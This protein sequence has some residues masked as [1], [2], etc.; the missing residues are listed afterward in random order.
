[1]KVNFSAQ[2]QNINPQF[3]INPKENELYRAF[4]PAS[5]T[6][7][8]PDVYLRN[9]DILNISLNKLAS[10]KFNKE[11]IAK[12]QRYGVKQIF[13]D[14]QE[15]LSFAKNNDIKIVFGKVD[16]QDVH[17]QWLQ[18]ENKI[19]IND[20]YKD[21][22]SMAEV[23]A[24]S[25]A[26]FHE[27]SHAKDRDGISSIQEEIDCLGM[28]ALAFNVFRKQNPRIFTK[29]SSPIIKDGVELYTNLF[30]GDNEQTLLER[31]KLKY[32]SLPVESPNHKASAFAKKINN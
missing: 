4:L 30:L 29:D 17:A 14:G 20:T 9:P 16:K 13:K 15:A 24:I 32:G 8:N 25:A 19:I 23:L 18:D 22:R 10:L 7:Y 26:I 1:M 27:L 11:D 2:I 31:I 21:T 3:V 28:N 5:K 6:F 12:V